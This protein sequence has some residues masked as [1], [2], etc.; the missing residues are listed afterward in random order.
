MSHVY[1]SKVVIRTQTTK[2]LV[3][4]Y[5]SSSHHH[6]PVSDVKVMSVDN[7]YQFYRQIAVSFVCSNS[8]YPYRYYNI[9]A[10]PC[11]VIFSVTFQRVN[12]MNDSFC[13]NAFCFLIVHLDNKWA[14]FQLITTTIFTI[15]QIQ[16]QLKLMKF[17][18]QI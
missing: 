9:D 8:K 2:K 4:L 5:A 16:K 18:F 12:K 15:I 1:W 17:V 3:A 11:G 6:S 7:I 13:Y 10:H 14:V